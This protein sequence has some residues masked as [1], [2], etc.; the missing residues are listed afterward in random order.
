MPV[1]FLELI[2]KAPTATLNV[3]TADRGL[4]EIELTGVA[5]RDLAAIGKRFPAF[6][7]LLDG[8]GVGSIID[9]PE[10]LAAVIAASLGHCGDA[11]YEEHVGRFPSADVLRMAFAIIRLTFP[12]ATADPLPEGVGN[13][14]DVGASDQ[15]SPALLNS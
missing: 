6:A 7:K 9:N 13:G 11:Q 8:A 5:L 14:L 15:S 1:S 12:Q 10:A 3:D 2:P 4:Q